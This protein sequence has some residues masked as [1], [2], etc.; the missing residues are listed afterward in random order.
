MSRYQ[1]ILLLLEATN[2]QIDRRD[3]AEHGSR[4]WFM[5]ATAAKALYEQAVELA[6]ALNAEVAA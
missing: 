1:H 3:A 2:T 5:A 6:I 4:E